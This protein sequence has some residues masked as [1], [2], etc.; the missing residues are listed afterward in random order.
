MLEKLEQRVC[1]A[2]LRLVSECLVVA[3]WGNVSGI[4]RD[5]HLV[6]IKP[7]GV[8]YDDLKP[9]HMMVVSLATGEVVEG[10][11]RPSSDTPSHL[12]LYRAFAAIGGVVHTH[13]LFASAWAQAR[14]EIPPL[15]TTHADYEANTGKVIVERFADLD[16]L[17]MPAVLVASH[18]PFTWGRSP[19]GTRMCRKDRRLPPSVM[20]RQITGHTSTS[21]TARQSA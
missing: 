17:A 8:S 13:G 11:F 16:P 2:N 19:E 20:C 5:E 10:E 7:S 6:V 21:S 4:A 14:R 3:T 12:E 18:G 9:D 1:D 15:G